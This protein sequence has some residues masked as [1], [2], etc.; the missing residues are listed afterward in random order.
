MALPNTSE[1]IRVMNSLRLHGNYFIMYL[2]LKRDY[3]P[4]L[5]SNDPDEL[6]LA[7][8][9][10]EQRFNQIDGHKKRDCNSGDEF[11]P[12]TDTSTLI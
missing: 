6:D 9:K 8:T 10:E 4:G 5:M 1:T 12:T 3:K 7:R 11:L 2:I